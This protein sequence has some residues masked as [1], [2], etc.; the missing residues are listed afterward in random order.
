M[1]YSIISIA[2]CTLLFLAVRQ[3]DKKQ[4]SLE[5][6]KRYVEKLHGEFEEA[7]AK[8]SKEL[9]AVNDDLSSQTSLSIATAKK[10]EEL[11]QNYQAACRDIADKHNVISE[12]SN[13]MNDANTK[14]Q[15]IVDMSHLLEV[16]IKQIKDEAKFVDSVSTSIKKAHTDLDAIRENVTDMQEAF[17]KENMR[18]LEQQKKNIL[19]ELSEQLATIKADLATTKKDADALLDV[20]KIKLNDIYKNTLMEAAQRANDLEGEAFETLKAQSADRVSMYRRELDESINETKEL[21]RQFKS[22]WQEEA[23]GMVAKMQSDFNEAETAI[24]AKLER[25]SKRVSDTESAILTK[26]K[27]LDETLTKNENDFTAKI[28]DIV[29]SLNDKIEHLS[30]YTENRL[31]NIKEQTEYRFKKF[32]A[33][34]NE[35]QNSEAT[36][37]TLLAS[38]KQNVTAS[39]DSFKYDNE[40]AFA[41]FNETF[42]AKTLE[43]N[44]NLLEIETQVD[45]LK[46][47]S[48][49]NISEK[50]KVFE[51]EFF[52]DITAKKA[53]IDESIEAIKRE[54]TENLNEFMNVQETTR[55]ELESQY[56]T[57]LQNRLVELANAHKEKLSNFDKQIK[58]I[59]SNLTTRLAEQNLNIEKISENLKADVENARESA[60]TNLKMEIDN[61]MSELQTSIMESQ[62]QFDETSGAMSE[63][64]AV[65]KQE[66]D[67]KIET[68][69]NNFQ[70]WKNSLDKQFD[71]A[72]TLFNDKIAS[73]GLLAEN[74]IKDFK[75]RHDADVEKF[76][77]QNSDVFTKM[78]TDMK[79]ITEKLDTYKTDMTQHSSK[80][81]SELD[82]KALAISENFDTVMQ[83]KLDAAAD[84]VAVVSE[85]IAEVKSQIEKNKAEAFS[86][87][88]NESNRL[89][90]SMQELS[91]KQNEYLSNTK[92]FERTDEL[93]NQLDNGIKTLQAE[94]AKLSVYSSTIDD[95]K[96]KY[97]KFSHQ[98][99]ETLSKIEK[100][101]QEKSKVELLEQEF[102]KLMGLSES[103][104][105]KQ[106]ELEASN[107]EMQKYQVQIRKLDD[108]ITLVN[109]KYQALNN[110]EEILTQ[111]INDISKAFSD[112][113]SIDSQ[114]KE[115]KKNLEKLNPEIVK[116]QAEMN[117]LIKNRAETDATI[118]KIKALGN[119]QSEVDERMKSLQNSKEWLVGIESRLNSLDETVTQRIKLFAT[120]YNSDD[121]KPRAP[122]S[123]LSN[124]DRENIIQ[125]HHMGWTNEQI[126]NNLKC[127]LSE[128][129]LILEFSDKYDD[130]NFEA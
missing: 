108:S 110:K 93:K 67:A 44:Q 5:K 38:V 4:G 12:L 97:E 85:N 84:R 107:D 49:D 100:F 54:I 40:K 64:I 29:A 103:I 50:L 33:T 73:F 34:V 101:M 2:I 37:K 56:T 79:T 118:E 68:A 117:N 66:Y 105:R 31:A 51:D 71:S 25:I 99:Q 19:Q 119:M 23:S 20:T 116:L 95:V 115:S 11:Q 106:I 102:T 60:K 94:L 121:K 15:Q 76:K 80:V 74:A 125:L 65:F 1:V 53:S 43:L 58:G 120:V 126:A 88:Q 10:L 41:A 8:R 128:I 55:K 14:F 9:R 96:L 104:E 82:E 111:I 77:E 28:R 87:I 72:R 17:R 3:F 124:S 89:T 69:N 130:K 52:T 22:V 39:F 75:E 122:N 13:S 24:D 62:Q 42:K 113:N 63:H 114:Y 61:Y 7:Y 48:Y 47:K 109:E 46:T 57:D 90:A 16:N 32:D 27:D 70:T 81:L 91:E 26:S 21:S 45:E 78:K 129:E 83:E 86:L 18:F 59:E 35:F 6:V 30:G 36:L 127:T 98:N 123:K 92:L 112:L